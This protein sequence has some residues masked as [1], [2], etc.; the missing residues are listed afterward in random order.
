MRLPSIDA[1]THPLFNCGMIN[2]PI[3]SKAYSFMRLKK[4]FETLKESF[5]TESVSPFIGRFN[6][7]NVNVGILAPPEHD[8]DAW[9]Y[10]CPKYWSHKDMPIPKIIDFR[11]SLINSRSVNNV[12]K[13]TSFLELNQL[14]ALSSKPVD[15]EINLESKPSLAMRFDSYMAPQGPTAKLRKAFLAGNPRIHSKVDKVFSDTSLKANDAVVY[16][17]DNNFDETFLSRILSVGTLGKAKDRKLVPTRWS[18]TATDDMLGKHL[19]KEIIDNQTMDY[20][21]FFGGYLGNY[22]LILCFPE[23][24]SYELFEMHVSNPGHY[25]TDFESHAGRKDYAVHTAGGYYT[26]RLAIL[27]KLKSLKRQASSIALRFITGDYTLPL[28][29]WVTRESARKALQARPIV[30]GSQDLLIKYAAALAKRKFGVDIQYIVKKSILLKKIS[31][32][33]KLQTFISA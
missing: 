24:W 22:Y 4:K 20:T 13:R 5:M 3:C 8:S 21:A 31:T 32:Q 16:L 33:R 30:F 19:H 11:S 25:M 1:K 10:D 7:P 17:Y 12:Q 29:V 23:I 2:C 9:M 14:A 6:Y 28:G 26:V 15:I 27:E 18:I